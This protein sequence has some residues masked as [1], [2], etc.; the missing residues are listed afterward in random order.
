MPAERSECVVGFSHESS[1]I[2]RD[3][4]PLTDERKGGERVVGWGDEKSQVGTV[5]APQTTQCPSK[6]V[7]RC[8]SILASLSSSMTSEAQKSLDQFMMHG[9]EQRK[10]KSIDEHHHAK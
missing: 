3:P 9:V 5:I 4:F 2:L 1:P 10:Q 7:K 6:T 8:L